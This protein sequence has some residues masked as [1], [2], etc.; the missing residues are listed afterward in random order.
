MG[1]TKKQVNKLMTNIFLKGIDRS[2]RIYFFRYDLIGVNF[3][4]ITSLEFGRW[5]IY[6]SILVAVSNFFIG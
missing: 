6:A 4:N 2:R 3:I 1:I 5:A